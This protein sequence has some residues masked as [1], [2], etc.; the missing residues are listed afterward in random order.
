[1]RLSVEELAERRRARD[2]QRNKDPR[3]KEQQR[4]LYLVNKDRYNTARRE[5][6]RANPARKAAGRERR[7][8]WKSRNIEQW[9]ARKRFDFDA[10]YGRISGRAAVLLRN[11]KKRATANGLEFDLTIDWVIAALETRKCEA[12]QMELRFDKGR[13]PWSPSLDRRDSRKGYT[14][15]NVQVVCFMYNLCK[16]NFTEDEVLAMSNSLVNA[17]K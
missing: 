6:L 4:Q 10:C 15:K 11:A 12:T 1:M 9:R 13:S 14:T 8:D 16:S 3:R 5:E 17:K 7:R 2:R